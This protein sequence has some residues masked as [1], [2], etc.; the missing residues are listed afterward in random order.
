MVSWNCVLCVLVVATTGEHGREQ[1][2]EKCG[3]GSTHDL[4]TALDL[5]HGLGMVLFFRHKSNYDQDIVEGD[6]LQNIVFLRPQ[7]VA[8]IVRMVIRHNIDK[9]PP[10]CCV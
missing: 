7:W 4:C 9:V 3:F 8:N 1:V 5:M 2:G 6:E 10:H